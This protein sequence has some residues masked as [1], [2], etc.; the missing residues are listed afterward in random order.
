VDDRAARTDA[1]LADVEALPDGRA[2]ETALRAL[3]AVVELYGDGLARIAAA[4]PDAQLAALATDNLVAHL[5][6]LHDLHPAGVEE[7]VQAALDEVRPYLGSHGG[8]VQLLEASAQRVR[9]RLE[10]SCSGCPSSTM[11]LK[12][13][14]ED[15]IRKHAPEVEAVEAEGATEPPK[16]PALLQL[17]VGDGL[18][19]ETVGIHARLRDGGTL[20][21]EVGGRP[22]LFLRLEPDTYA[23]GADCPSCGGSLADASLTGGELCCAGCGRRYDVRRAGRCVDSPQLHLNPVPLLAT[24]AGLVK[25]AVGGA[26]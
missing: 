1:L 10:G 9:L 12:L 15:A 16:A 7:R 19:W 22:M 5:L 18:R 11:T 8:S 21:H 20:L 24:D 17:E 23:Y 14:I 25:V 6:L 4:L 2:R 13:A 26:A 3:R